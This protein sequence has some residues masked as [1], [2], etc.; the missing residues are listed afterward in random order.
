MFFSQHTF[1]VRENPAPRLP[2]SACTVQKEEHSS[3]RHSRD[4]K[5]RSLVICLGDLFFIPSTSLF[6]LSRHTPVWQQKALLGTHDN[7][8]VPPHQCTFTS[9]GG[10]KNPL[11]GRLS[12]V[13]CAC[14]QCD[15]D[16]DRE[17]ATV[18][19]V[20][21][22]SQACVHLQEPSPACDM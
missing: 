2:P 11:K 1:T 13:S 10:G 9:E 22:L 17:H 16:I 4:Q 14:Q 6:S 8:M 20:S 18:Y 21:W 19:A 5:K 12:Q 15:V 3:T 7:T